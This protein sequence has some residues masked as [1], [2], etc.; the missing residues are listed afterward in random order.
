[1]V[2]ASDVS[3]R[4]NLDEII[5]GLVE[6]LK[7]LRRNEISVRDARARADLGREILR[8]VRLV[9]EARKFIAGKALPLNDA[10][11]KHKRGEGRQQERETDAARNDNPN[12]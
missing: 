6:D 7:A 2:A 8:G 5:L 10:T 9:I 12:G 1:M 11:P 3:E 4:L